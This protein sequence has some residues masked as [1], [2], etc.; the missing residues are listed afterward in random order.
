MK[1]FAIILGVLTCGFGAYALMFPTMTG[2]SISL[3]LGIFLILFGIRGMIEGFSKATKNTMQGV[4]GV[5]YTLG[6]IF[7]CSNLYTAIIVDKYIVFI[8][9]IFLII[10]GIFQCVA[11]SKAYSLDKT[12][13]T[14]IWVIVLG[15]LTILVGLFALTHPFATLLSIG[16]IIAFNLIMQGINLIIVA[17]AS[18]KA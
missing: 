2:L 16:Y 14:P 17:C 5:L 7:L 1:V 8:F 6:G 15:V 4:L 18:P 11:G 12:N 3:I 9:A 10:Y 13:K